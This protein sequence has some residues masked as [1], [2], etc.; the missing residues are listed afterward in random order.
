MMVFMAPPKRDFGFAEPF[1]L[2]R[3]V[4]TSCG[5]FKM[6]CE[7]DAEGGDE[8]NFGFQ[9]FQLRTFCS[10]DPARTP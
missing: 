9:N 10:A 5:R 7:D 8:R 3:G 4:L 2:K 6:T 1:I